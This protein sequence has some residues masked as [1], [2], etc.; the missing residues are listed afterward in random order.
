[1]LKPICIIPARGGSKGV[2]RK[3]IRILGKKPLISYSIKTALESNLFQDVIISTEDSE[4]A[5]IA[6]KYGGKI[7]FMRPKKLGKDTTTTE[8]VL[9]HV[10]KEL[11]DLKYDFDTIVLRDCT[12]PFIDKKDMKKALQKF[13]KNDCNAVFASIKAHPNPYFGMMEIKNN[14]YL[15]QSKIPKSNVTRRQDAPIVYNVDGMF[16][17]NVKYFLKTKKISS[18]KIIPFEITKEHGHM[19]DFEFD[20]EVADLLINNK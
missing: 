10:I 16:I 2:K 8:E 12:V 11:R 19:I 9:L 15:V 17:L 3:N 14:G 5:K 20:F 1:M 7:P 4:I 6:K 13:Y 18:G